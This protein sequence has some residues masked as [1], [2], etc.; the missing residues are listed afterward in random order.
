MDSMKG[1]GA[2]LRAMLRR[3]TTEQELDEEIRFHLELETEKN[4]RLGMNDIEARRR[5]FVN[6]GGVQRAK[7]DHRDVRGSHWIEELVADVRFALRS[8]LHS[9]ALSLAAILTLSLGIGANTAIFSAV[10]AVIL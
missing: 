1:I 4:R 9:P 8:L 10:N 6:F 2:R 5:A 7:E 3:E